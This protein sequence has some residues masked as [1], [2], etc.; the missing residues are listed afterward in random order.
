MKKRLKMVIL[1]AVALCLLVLW[2]RLDSGTPSHRTGRW[3]VL[4]ATVGT[5]HRLGGNVYINDKHYDIEGRAIMQGGDVGSIKVEA[6]WH[7]S[8]HKEQLPELKVKNDSQ[9]GTRHKDEEDQ[10]SCLQDNPKQFS[11]SRLVNSFKSVMTKGGEIDTTKYANSQSE[12][13]KLLEMLGTVFSFV[14]SD[15]KSKIEILEAYRASEQGEHYATI[16][17]MLQYEKDTGIV[18][19]NKKPS[20]ARTLLRLH[21]ALKFIME[22][23]NRMGKSTSDAKVS[24]L[25]YECYHETLANYHVWIVRK[26]A[27]MA[28]YTLPTRK[29]FLEKLCKEEEDVVLGLVSE[30]AATVL[31]VYEQTEELY[32][33]FDFHELP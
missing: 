13:M 21:R 12:L 14:T 28:F 7:K 15:A 30:L 10:P 9:H 33:K 25:A 8:E 27:G 4:Q 6:G 2:F 3:N 23:L 18:L 1:I 32:T 20:G 17:S 31:P 5:I 19:D 16:E 11:L 24:T 22:F 26:A 29:N